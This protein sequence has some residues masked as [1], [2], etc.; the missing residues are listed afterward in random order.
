M[1]Q[2][3]ATPTPEASWELKSSCCS[4][5]LITETRTKH[6]LGSTELTLSDERGW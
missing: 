5:A 3:G 1:S 6:S 4:E 2:P